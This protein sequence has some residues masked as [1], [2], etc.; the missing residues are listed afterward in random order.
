MAALAFSAIS[1]DRRTRTDQYVPTTFV[2]DMTKSN[3][4]RGSTDRLEGTGRGMMWA[5]GVGGSWP[6]FGLTHQD[7]VS[8]SY[9][10]DYKELRG[11]VQASNGTGISRKVIALSQITHRVLGSTISD[12]GTGAFTLKLETSD[13]AEVT[14]I[15]LPDDADQKNS[16]SFRDITPVPQP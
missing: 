7:R 16:V 10:A 8:A 2:I 4:N 15:A 13:E 1:F 12:P 14:V 6:L 3:E 5:D 11:V 9:F